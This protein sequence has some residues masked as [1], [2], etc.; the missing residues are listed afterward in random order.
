MCLI[1]GSSLA[2]PPTPP[3]SGTLIELPPCGLSSCSFWSQQAAVV[4]WSV[5]GSAAGKVRRSALLMHS[6]CQ[7]LYTTHL[8]TFQHLSGVRPASGLREMLNAS[9]PFSSLSAE[10][11]LNC[12]VWLTFLW[13][14]WFITYKN[15]PLS[16]NRCNKWECWFI[17]HC[18]IHCYGTAVQMNTPM[19]SIF[20]TLTTFI[21]TLFFI[22][23]GRYRAS[24]LGVI[25]VCH[26]PRFKSSWFAVLI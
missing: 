9:Q 19:K 23:H 6:P 12:K 5:M 17:V 8:E 7:N 10:V 1:G 20:F 18:Y 21:F 4:N 25:S 22:S 16:C 13:S 14:R 2:S 24:T 26:G 11:I 3:P 15:L